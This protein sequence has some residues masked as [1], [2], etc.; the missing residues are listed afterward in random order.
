MTSRCRFLSVGLLALL[1]LSACV[2]VFP[3]GAQADLAAKLQ[4]ANAAF[5]QAFNAV[6]DAE[7]SGANV[8]ALVAQLNV[9][10]ASLAEAENSYRIGDNAAATVNAERV[11]SLVQEVASASLDAKQAALV[12][13]A[14]AF[15]SAVALA[16]VGSAVFLFVMFL[17]W[18]WFKQRYINNMLEAKPEVI[19]P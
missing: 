3:V 10:A 11:L 9:A 12:S 2:A 18:R 7:A 4:E 13:E 14:N 5:E 15:W 1:V 16:V 17:V 8:T 19:S 6:L